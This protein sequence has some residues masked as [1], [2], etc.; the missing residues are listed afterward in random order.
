MDA[1]YSPFEGTYVF[2]KQR[3]Q[4]KRGSLIELY[5][6]EEM[7]PFLDS[8][9]FVQDL[10]TVSNSGVLRGLHFQVN[11]PQGKLISVLHGKIFD[12]FVDIRMDSST[13]GKWHSIELSDEN[14]LQVYLPP[15]FA[16][17]FLTMSEKARVSYKVT[18]YWSRKDERSLIWNENK[19]GIKWPLKKIN[20]TLPKLSKKD[21][22][23]KSIDYLIEKGE[24]F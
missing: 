19:V 23:A 9:I 21:S 18:N 17:G 16:H 6:K 11:Y 14:A 20:E 5:R 3:F 7:L 22:D 13:F 8:N 12:V 10:F 15:G 4:D 1:I 2:Q 24:F